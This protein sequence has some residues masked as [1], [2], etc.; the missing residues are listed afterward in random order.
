MPMIDATKALAVTLTLGTLSLGLAGAA[1]AQETAAP[2]EQPAAE[3]PATAQPT[4]EAPAPAAAP[5]QAPAADGPGSIYVKETNGTWETRCMRM[6][7]GKDEPCQIYQL[8]KDAQGGDVAELAVFPLPAGEKAV[9][10]ATVS[11]PLETLLTARLTLQID[12]NKPL[13][14]EYSW[15]DQMACI[16][17]IGFT[18]ADLKAMKNGKE[19]TMTIVPARA[20]DQKVA[21]K[22]SLSGI[23]K[24]F[25][26]LP[27]PV[28]PQQ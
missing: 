4:A 9:A 2:A 19:A 22:V 17:R 13:V 21:L 1:I 14:Y 25:D 12:Q 10:G 5:A 24:G 26:S 16:A 18:D 8:L 15:C 27:V 20:P 23:T 3:Q 6:P 11:V 7:E 28:K